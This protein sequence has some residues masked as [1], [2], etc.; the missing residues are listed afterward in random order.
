MSTTFKGV[1]IANRKIPMVK[2]LINNIIN[3]RFN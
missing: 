1:R 3:Y 2:N